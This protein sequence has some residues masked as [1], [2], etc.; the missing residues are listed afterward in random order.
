MHIPADKKTAW[1][2]KSTFDWV[3]Q[4]DDELGMTIILPEGVE[5]ADADR[6][7]MLIKVGQEKSISFDFKKT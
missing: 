2:P 3:P 6:Q 1:L 7:H 4:W 5:Y